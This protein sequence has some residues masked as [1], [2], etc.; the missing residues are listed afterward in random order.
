VS[1]KRQHSNIL[2]E[3]SWNYLKY[4]TV[5]KQEN[6]K[7]NS[8]ENK[9]VYSICHLL[10]IGGLEMFFSNNGLLKTSQKTKD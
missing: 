2:E 8:R 7:H 6:A 4:E 3:M 5:L 9:L 1:F 10:E